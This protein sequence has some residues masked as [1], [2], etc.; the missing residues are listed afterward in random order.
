[1]LRSSIPLLAL[2]ALGCAAGSQPGFRDSATPPADSGDVDSGPGDSSVLDTGGADTGVGD[3]GVTDSAVA[4][5]GGADTGMDDSGAGDS[6]AADSA[7][8]DSG[9]MDSGADSGMSDGG[10]MDTGAAD[11]GA[12][13]GAPSIVLD[14]T[15]TD[16]EWAGAAIARNTTATDWGVGLNHLD[17]LR[18]AVVGDQ[19]YLAVEGAVE[20]TNGLV[21]YVDAH[22]GDAAG[23]S[24]MSALTDTTGSLDNAV[25]STL[26]APAAFKADFAFGTR[27]MSH[28]GSGF[29]PDFGWRDIASNT[30]DFAWITA[31][32]SG[33]PGVCSAN[34]CETR[35]PLATLGAVRGADVGVFVRI[36]NAMGNDFSNQTLP[37]DMP[38]TPATV[39][40]WL[41]LTVP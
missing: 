21:A 37:E 34:A 35:I 10:A 38:A 32:D 4:D 16:A 20:S 14:G 27:T 24:D 19:L 5:T 28:S 36:T 30:A 17:A 15:V 1:M 31:A 2:L 3:S 39:S 26:V 33:A 7:A 12:D 40:R 41:T 23:V 9:S 13:S 8:A 22:V 18:V 25:S 29:D 6:A 11:T